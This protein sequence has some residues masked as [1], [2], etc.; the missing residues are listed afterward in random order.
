MQSLISLIEVMSYE[1]KCDLVSERELRAFWG[2]SVLGFEF[3]KASGRSGG[4]IS[5]WDSSIFVKSNVLKDKNYLLVSGNLNGYSQTI[6]IVNIY[7]PQR[8]SDKKSLWDTLENLKRS[9]PGM[10]IM[11]GDFNAVRV[12][13]DRRNTSFNP[14]CQRRDLNEE[15]QWTYDECKVGLIEVEDSRNKDFR[16]RSRVKWASYGDDNSAFFHR[17]IKKHESRNRIHGLSINGSWCDK[18]TLIKKEARRFFANRFKNSGSSNPILHCQHMKQLSDSEAASLILPFTPHEIKQA[19]WDCGEDRAPGPDGFNFRFL[20]RYWDLLGQDI[21]NVLHHFHHVESFSRGCSSSYIALI[22]KILDPSELND[23]RPIHLIG[24]VSKVVSKV[25][26]SRLKPVLDTIISDTQSAFIKKRNIIDGPLVINEIISWAKKKKL[27]L[28]LF[29]IDFEKA[30][31]HISWDFL[32]NIQQQMNFPEKWRR[33]IM[34]ILKSARSS[35]LVNG[36]PTFEFQYQRG[37]RQGDPLS[38]FLFILGMEALSCMFNKAVETNLFKGCKLPNN[39][40][41]ISHLLYA[42]DALIVGEGNLSNVRCMTR[43]LRC[44]HLASGLKINIS[45]SKL[46]GIGLDQNTV[47]CMANEIHCNPGSLPFVY[48]GLKVGTNMNRINNWDHVINVFDRRLA[49]WKSTSLSIGGRLTLLKAVM[50]T[51]PTYYFSIYKAPVKILDILEAKR[52][53]FLWNATDS[54]RGICWVSWDRVTSPIEAGGLGLTPLRDVN[55]ALLTKWWWRFKT[56]P[57]VLWRRVI[58]SI[59]D[60]PR[61]WPLLPHAKSLAGTWNSIARLENGLSNMGISISSLIKGVVGNGMQIRFWLD[62]WIA[63]QPLKNMFPTLYNMERDKGKLI[64]N[65]I[66]MWNGQYQWFWSWKRQPSSTLELMELADLT[67]LIAIPIISQQEDSWLWM[68]DKTNTFTVATMKK[69]QCNSRIPNQNFIMEWNNWIPK[70]VNIFMWQAEQERIQ[71]RRN[72]AIRQIPIDSM[73]CPLCG[74]INESATHLFCE[75]EMA[76][77]IW[78]IITNWL[79]IPPIFV[80][81]IQD[82]LSIHNSIPIASEKKKKAIHGILMTTCWC[83]WKARNAAIFN[84]EPIRIAAIMESIKSLGFLWIKNRSSYNNLS[85]RTWCNAFF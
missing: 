17:T 41:S 61:T 19:V 39:G 26:S 35:V 59:H 78:A 74:I 34:G 31:D 33:W 66:L 58:L 21:I 37:V 52:R 5:M 80:F 57:H 30:F 62:R 32:D 47:E 46:T 4:I 36:S 23:F 44:F 51:I 70:K 69:L 56:E 64:G 54:D 82:I 16:Q 1:S 84:N 29:K 20:K 50:E 63:Q 43:L 53:R 65:S 22:P 3:V 38:P 18:P 11:F 73:D 79:K 13:E 42:D 15:E 81:S 77:T 55:V 28:F 76:S 12:I 10:W 75:C 2:N 9:M 24:S 7:A 14:V 27:K 83:I 72:L 25:L 49:L 85:W 6:H 48:L 67:N 71:T 60:T 8:P 68:D 45:K 40:P